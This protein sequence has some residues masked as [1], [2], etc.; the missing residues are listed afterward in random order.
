MAEVIC[1]GRSIREINSEIKSRIRGGDQQITVK[2]PG[3]RHNLAVAILEPAHVTIEG[4]AGYYCGALADGSTVEVKGSAGWGLAESMLNGTA[5]VHGSAGNGAGAAIR[6]GAVIVH[7]DAAARAAVS[8]KGGLVLIG[9]SCGYMAGF[10]GQKG[11]LIVCGDTGD[12]FADSMYATVCYVGGKIKGLGTDTV[13]E[14]LS[15]QDVE[16][17]DATLERYL[18]FEIRKSKPAGKAFKKVVSGRRL[19]NFSQRDRTIWQEAL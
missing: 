4:S 8:M 17:L 16:F 18:P 3:A 7:G 15:S 14:D 5:I 13:R 6:G 12:A 2:D 1:C 10:M 11:S 19:W 9:G